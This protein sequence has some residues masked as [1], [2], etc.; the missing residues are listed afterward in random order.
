M[1]YNHFHQMNTY[2]TGGGGSVICT[3]KL[4]A[5]NTSQSFNQALYFSKQTTQC[6]SKSYTPGVISGQVYP[7]PT[8][9]WAALRRHYNGITLHSPGHTPLPPHSPHTLRGEEYAILFPHLKLPAN[10]GSSAGGDCA[11]YSLTLW[12]S[13]ASDWL[14]ADPDVPIVRKSCP[15]LCLL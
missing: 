5:Q 2:Q 14:D 7:A 12:R 9:T 3:V 11:G 4:Q 10:S 13:T 1:Q 6:C 8:Q 15:M